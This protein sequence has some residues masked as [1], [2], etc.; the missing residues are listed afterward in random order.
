MVNVPSQYVDV[1][2][3][4]WRV[5]LEDDW[6]IRFG[7]PH[8]ESRAKNELFERCKAHGV[9]VTG[10]SIRLRFPRS[11]IL[12]ANEV[13]PEAA[14]ADPLA[15]LEIWDEWNS[16]IRVFPYPGQYSRLGLVTQQGKTS[17]PS[18]V[19]VLGEIMAGLFAQAYIAPWPLVRVVRYWPDLIFYSSREG[20]YSFVEAK[21]STGELGGYA[22]GLPRRVPATL[23]GECALYA[24][25][26]INSDPWVKVWG[27]FTVVTSI[28]PFHLTVTFVEFDATQGR[29]PDISRRMMPH[30]V[31]TGLASR[32]L[33]L[34]AQR[35]SPEDLSGLQ[36][37]KRHY[38]MDAVRRLTHEARKHIEYLLIK[39]GPETAVSNSRAAIESEIEKLAATAT[40][41]QD[42]EREGRHFFEARRDAAQGAI[43]P[44]RAV[45][46]QMIN[47]RDL[48]DQ[49]VEEIE[50]GW[51]AEWETAA[52]S[53][54]DGD[55]Q[56]AWRFGG[57]LYWLGPPL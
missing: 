39:A 32:A 38:R 13:F 41:P 7:S 31:V 52:A 20:R 25:Q 49:E 5:E 17:A 12:L 11:Q 55:G 4:H 35:M 45:G 57:S 34:A 18:S 37:R 44:I 27:A 23:L 15:D 29:R 8:Y 54:R 50:R 42:Q 56:E 14:V 43:A 40:V 19:G 36:P 47:V 22:P 9:P 46:G 30:A 1:A 3:Q 6:L 48:R 28:S 16:G 51:H 21:A 2:F 33:V 24:V 26:Q 10:S 53:A